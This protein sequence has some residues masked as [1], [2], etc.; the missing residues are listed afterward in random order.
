MVAGAVSYLKQMDNVGANRAAR[1]SRAFR[2]AWWNEQDN[3]TFN[4]T[5]ALSA[6]WQRSNLSVTFQFMT[7]MTRSVEMLL[8]KNGLSS[9]QRARLLAGNILL[10]GG[11]GVGVGGWLDEN[12]ASSG[13]ASGLDDDTFELLRMGAIGALTNS[14]GLGDISPR[15]APAQGL[16]D[17]YTNI[18]EKSY[19]EVVSGPGGAII[20]DL[21]ADSWEL[22]VNLYSYEGVTTKQDLAKFASTISTGS[23]A[24]K[25]FYA[26]RYGEYFNRN[27][28][29]IADGLDM[30]DAVGILMGATPKEVSIAYR[31]VSA[32]KAMKE[33]AIEAGKLIGKLM[34]RYGDAKEAG[35]EDLATNIRD[36][37]FTAMAPLSPWERKK[38]ETYWKKRYESLFDSAMVRQM[39]I[40]S[41]IWQQHSE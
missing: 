18:S 23:T 30:P 16:L 9:A 41:Q 19:V 15:L 6:P 27:G 24:L 7:Y 35:D 33:G 29:L 40:G 4:M 2:D 14:I 10:Y 20:K 25:I 39:D 28:D 17:W 22:G 11:T 1:N 32:Q 8:R 26:M 36:Q 38:G 37:I 21:A 13:W 34:D 12:R 5:S 31:T 3:L